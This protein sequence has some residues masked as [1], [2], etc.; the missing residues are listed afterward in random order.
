M[1]LL[2][3]AFGALIAMACGSE[4]GQEANATTPGLVIDSRTLRC[5]DADES[6]Q[7]GRDAHANGWVVS[8]LGSFGCENGEQTVKRFYVRKA[9]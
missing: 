4:L 7:F 3:G 8:T 6:N 9:L 2:S 1:C 5:A